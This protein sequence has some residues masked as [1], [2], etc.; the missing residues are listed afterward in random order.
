MSAVIMMISCTADFEEINTNPNDPTAVAPEFLMRQV[1]YDLGEELSYEGFVAGNLLS[2]HF[3][4]V[5]FNLFDR[6]ALSDPQLGGN[7]WPV[8]YSNLRDVQTILNSAQEDESFQPYV[9]PALILKGYIQMALTDIYGNVPIFEAANGQG[10]MTTPAYDDQMDIYLAEDG[11]RS[12]LI[13]G[14]TAS[15]V[16]INTTI[17]GDILYNG[18]LSKWIAFSNSLLIKM[19]M[20][21]S[22]AELDAASLQEIYTNGNFITDNGDNAAFDFTDLQPNSFRMQQLRDGDFNLFVMSETMDDI[23]TELEDP[24]VERLFRPN[25]T[26]TE[27]QGL[28]NGPDASSTSLTV[29]DFSFAGEI[30]REMTGQI[31]ANFMTA[32]ETHFLLAEAAERGW[33]DANAKSHYDQAV[34]LAFEYW[35]VELPVDYLTGNAAYGMNGNEEIE[36]II[37]QKWIANIINGYE[38]WI[39]F[40]RTGFP[41]LK[42]IS[43]SLNNDLLPVRMPYP[44]EEQALN[45]SNFEAATAASGNDI[46]LRVWWDVD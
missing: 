9:G 35:G 26:G 45:Q 32:W 38:S 30:F 40:R 13:A 8:L 29:S 33:I 23:L 18:D 19:Y 34:T 4:M 46:N 12:N 44:S 43:A 16:S 2:Q 14:I 10:G 28:L 41:E 37:T 5:D 31:D 24:R 17:D 1:I 36:Q 42:A 11:I 20:R 6:H 21:I 39:E 3:T 25:G 22:G 15:Q 27:Y 7:P